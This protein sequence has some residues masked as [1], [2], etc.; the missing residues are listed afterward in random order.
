MLEWFPWL[1][2]LAALA[3]VI[4]AAWLRGRF[5][6]MFAA[7]LLTIHTLV[8]SALAPSFGEL[9]PLYA[10]F[11]LAV[12]AHFAF[13]TRPNMRPVWYRALVSLPA[14]FFAAG[15]FLAL[16][17]AVAAA[18]GVQPYGFFIPYA[19]AA[20]GLV[21]SLVH[22]FEEIDVALDDASAPALARWSLGA[23]DPAS[24]PLRI[25]QITD[26]HL[27]PFMS[28]A[29]LRDIATRA[30]AANPDLVLLTGDFLT[31]E[32]H[33]ARAVLARALA[34]LTALPPGRVFACR[35][36]H[37]LEAPDTVEGALQ[38]IGARLLIDESQV[39]DTPA[40]PV[41]ILG[42]DFHFRD[43]A[44]RTRAAC[45]SHPRIPGH[46]RLVLL[47]DPGAF[48]HLPDGEADLVLSGH[49][50]GGQLGLLTLGLPHTFVSAFTDIP[51]HGLWAL[52]RNRLYVH[53]GT[54]HYGFPLRV[55][56]PGEES[57][58]RIH[59]SAATG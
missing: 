26:P 31:M 36:N 14:S 59:R 58:L 16:P 33:E 44:A 37:D 55:G 49:T 39:V 23:A 28:E 32:S 52:G 3:V 21:Q 18:F 8:S 42:I 17:W 53:R 41:Q 2:A 50:H 4:L 22:R 38:D 19:V 40:G 43:R 34:P 29:R 35:G 5:Y 9:L 24:R 46:L 57:L 27:G 30:V 25:V 54:G 48:K 10:Y 51:D 56:V 6:A 1:S 47:H 45:A 7:V 11:Q 13:L 20:V 12:F 15:T